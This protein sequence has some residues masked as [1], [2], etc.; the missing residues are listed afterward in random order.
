MSF[1]CSAAKCLLVAVMFL[2]LIFHP[3]MTDILIRNLK[4]TVNAAKR[5][6]FLSQ[7]ANEHFNVI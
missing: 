6:V 3:H 2:Y 4:Q 5:I 1:H 7:C